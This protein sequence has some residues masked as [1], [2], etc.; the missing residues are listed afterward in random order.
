MNVVSTILVIIG[1][2]AILVFSFGFFFL[3]SKKHRPRAKKVVLIAFI[4]ALVT[5]PIVQKLDEDA[6]EL[7]TQQAEQQ[8]LETALAAG[9]ESVAE[10]Q[11]AH[12]FNIKS[13]D[14]WRVRREALIAV[15]NAKL[16]AERKNAEE[17][18]IV[19]LQGFPNEDT[20]QH[21]LS[22]GIKRYEAYRFLNDQQAIARYCAH[23]VQANIFEKDKHRQMDVVKTEAEKN[24]I[25]NKYEAFQKKLIDKLNNDLGLEGFEFVE[26]SGKGFWDTHCRAAEQ[27]WSV[28]TEDQAKA[29]TRSDANNAKDALLL[30]YLFNLEKGATAFFNKQR[31][32]TASCEWENHNGMRVVGC[33]L[34]SF[35]SQSQWQMF[36]VGRLESSRLAISPID[37]GT[38][39]N[40]NN[41]LALFQ[42][43]A[44]NKRIFIEGQ[45]QSAAYL[46]RYAGPAIDINTV[47]G[48][49]K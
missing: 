21:A 30:F 17:A 26:V 4:I 42:D 23:S 35:K 47:R 40:L 3:F 22:L 6:Q 29:A 27:N 48:L 44:F 43:Q 2:I 33:R 39:R 20:Q 49:F 15:R 19:A 1:G 34:Q 25:W 37:G 14:E 10:Q 45:N 36:L 16:E 5:A 18:R 13:A 11:E 46:A 41:T 12:S 38:I 8:A 9:F 28:I 31:Y 24:E 32:N 7:A